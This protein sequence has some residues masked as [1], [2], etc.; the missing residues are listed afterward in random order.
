V[1]I[2]PGGPDTPAGSSDIGNL[3]HLLPIIHP[4]IQIADPGTPSHSE[5]MR[6]AAATP[7][8]HDR[9]QVAATGLGRVVAELLTAPGLLAAARAEFAEQ[10][11]VPV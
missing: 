10:S 3:S 4:Y 8:A 6:V 1:D 11:R 5:A 2:A 9:T 7:F